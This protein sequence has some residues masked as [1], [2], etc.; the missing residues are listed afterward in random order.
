MPYKVERLLTEPIV[1]ITHLNLIPEEH[2]AYNQ[3]IL[4][5]VDHASEPLYLIRNLLENTIFVP[6]DLIDS[7]P[8]DEVL[9][10]ILRRLHRHPNIIEQF[11]V[12]DVPV[13]NEDFY[14]ENGIYGTI[15][16]AITAIRQRQL[17]K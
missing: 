2:A 1:L 9:E 13:G 10:A 3:S 15:D 8:R 11:T 17:P 12:M 14:H 5:I 7:L 4:D 16:E 6:F